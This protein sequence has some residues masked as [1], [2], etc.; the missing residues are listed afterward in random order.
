VEDDNEEA[1]Q[2]DGWL[3]ESMLE[4]TRLLRPALLLGL[5]PACVSGAPRAVSVSRFCCIVCP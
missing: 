3:F 2:K 5:P 1:V 4:L